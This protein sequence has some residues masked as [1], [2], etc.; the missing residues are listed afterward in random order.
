MKRIVLFLIT[1]LAVVLVLSIV[2]RLF[3]LDRVVQ[4]N[5]INV[6]SL[7]VF[8]FVVGFAGSII[9]LLMSKAMA[10]WSTGAQVIDAPRNE[11]EA[12]RALL[13]RYPD[14]FILGSDTWTDDRWTNYQSIIDAYRAATEAK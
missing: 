5:G 1:N 7:L 2:L 14:R 3:G 9:S 12:W 10:K 11:A 8:S 4:A 13:L 6:P